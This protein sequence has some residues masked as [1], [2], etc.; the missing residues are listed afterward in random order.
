MLGKI[1]ALPLD[2][3]INEPAKQFDFSVRECFLVLFSIFFGPSLGHIKQSKPS[4]LHYRLFFLSKPLY[5][6]SEK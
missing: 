1:C 2:F 4:N 6:N 5:I 3:V